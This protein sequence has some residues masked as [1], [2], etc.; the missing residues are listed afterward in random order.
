MIEDNGVISKL[1][2]VDAPQDWVHTINEKNIRMAWHHIIPMQTFQLLWNK[3][4]GI[5]ARD[6]LE[7]YMDL[8]MVPNIENKI[9]MMQGDNLDGDS[10]NVLLS[11]ISWP[12]FNIVE[13][14]L[15]RSDDPKKNFDEFRNGLTGGELGRQED[16]Q[17][18]YKRIH[19]ALETRDAR[20]ASNMTSRAIKVIRR[21]KRSPMIMF[22]KCG[23]SLF[24]VGKFIV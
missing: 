18:F 22:K 5:R 2:R 13:G 8:L 10:K 19:H 24:C 3:L 17:W 16:L 14:P 9:A 7:K 23:S 21:Y 20:V 15:H 4:L 1:G 11:K 12:V 6:V